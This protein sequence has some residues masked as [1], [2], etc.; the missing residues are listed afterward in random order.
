MIRLMSETAFRLS[1]FFNS[2]NEVFNCWASLWSNVSEGY[3]FPNSMSDICGGDMSARCA[4]SLNERSSLFRSVLIS[5]PSE[6]A[7]IVL[8]YFCLFT[9]QAT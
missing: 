4:S 2:S 6:I 9:C 8:A 7:F 5:S 3:R 1:Y